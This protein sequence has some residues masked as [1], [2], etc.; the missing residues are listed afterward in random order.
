MA[1]GG[2]PE[3]AHSLLNPCACDA[4]SRR[5]AVWWFAM[6]PGGKPENAP[7]KRKVQKA[8]RD[9]AHAEACQV[10]VQWCLWH[11]L[12]VC[13]PMGHAV[14]VWLFNKSYVHVGQQTCWDVVR[15]LA[16]RCNSLLYFS[17]CTALVPLHVPCITATAVLLPAGVLGWW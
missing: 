17:T 5:A 9:Y 4:V 11:M 6:P 15:W 10:G 7:R 3:N 1:P 14:Y 16:V 8:G 2:K 13:F 12:L